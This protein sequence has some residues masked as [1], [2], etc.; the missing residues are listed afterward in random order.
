MIKR[1]IAALLAVLT[2]LLY[3][4]LAAFFR[5]PRRRI[6]ADPELILSPA[7]GVVRDVGETELRQEP[8]DGEAQRIGIFLTVFNDLKVSFLI[9]FFAIGDEFI[10]EVVNEV[11]VVLVELIK[12][13]VLIIHF[14]DLLKI[15][16]FDFC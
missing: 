8:F 14:C 4:C 10:C 6:P 7:D 1:T 2:L 13:C 5:S 16:N 3:F 11:G 12:F 9:C 15:L